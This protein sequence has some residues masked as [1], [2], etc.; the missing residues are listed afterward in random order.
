MS[1]LATSSVTTE[2][3]DQVLVIHLDDGRANAISF[4]LCAGVTAAIR[5]AEADDSIRAVVLHGREG[6]FSAG[7]DLSVMRGDDPQAIADLCA[8]GALLV[9][10]VYGSKVPVVAAC[11]G[12]ALAMGAMV[13]LGADIRVGADNDSKIGMN[14]LAIGLSLPD[15]ALTILGE[16]LDRKHLQMAIMAARI[17]SPA[18]AVGVGYLDEVV[19]AD[20]VL[21]RALEL[22]GG[23]AATIHPRSYR[24]TLRRLR[25][26]MLE[27]LKA[28]ADAFRNGGSLS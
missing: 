27:T 6:R 3:R 11:T 15:W 10:T 13:L 20:Q 17:Y 1:D 2:R 18:E 8:D 14:E 21:D 28:Q 19:P 12:H 5:A 24:S 16:R 22:A 23:L 9:H 25:G 4:E 26:P 7:F